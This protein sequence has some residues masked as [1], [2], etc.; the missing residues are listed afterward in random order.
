MIIEIWSDV[1][2]PFCYI[3][4]R[5]F[6]KALAAFPHK[7]EVKLVWKSFLLNPNLTEDSVQSTLDYIAAAKGMSPQDTQQMLAH[8]T[9]QA[10]EQGLDFNFETSK[11]TSTLSAHRLLQ[12]AKTFDKGDAMEERL[13]KA[14][15]TEGKLVSDKNV[16]ADL[17]SEI[18]LNKEEAE[19]VLHSGA[20][21]DKVQE[22]LYEAQQFQIQ[23][24]PFFILD[25]KYAVSGAQD[26]S[27]FAQALT[28]SFEEWK[29]GQ[30][31]PLENLGNAASCDVDGNCD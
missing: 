8:V 1:M 6:E 28:K 24:V 27:V 14:F 26:T 2:C 7:E 30:V 31:K 21:A 9:A 19:K 3:G 18:G 23:G 4:K 20:F 13:F 16:L 25:R 12:W 5:K 17:A 22:D 29:A 15:F 11:I 10:K